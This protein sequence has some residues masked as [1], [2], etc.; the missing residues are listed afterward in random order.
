MTI[1]MSDQSEPPQAV[2]AT[3]ELQ[4]NRADLLM[5]SDG[6]QFNKEVVV[7]ADD[8]TVVN[9]LLL[10]GGESATEARQ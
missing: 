2:D 10:L 4:L 8:G 9:L 7:E 5:L 1:R 3:L 6:H